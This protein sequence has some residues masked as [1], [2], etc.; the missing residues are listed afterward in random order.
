MQPSADKLAKVEK[1][2]TFDKGLTRTQVYLSELLMPT[3]NPAPPMVSGIQPAAS[4]DSFANWDD[5]AV[6]CVVLG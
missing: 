6:V 2:S 3:Y 4:S 1:A 5:D